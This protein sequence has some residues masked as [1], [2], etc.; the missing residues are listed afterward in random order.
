MI[1][2]TNMIHNERNIFHTVTMVVLAILFAGLLCMPAVT[3]DQVKQNT[4]Q[5]VNTTPHIEL[6]SVSQ[7]LTPNPDQKAKLS[8]IQQLVQYKANKTPAQGKISD[9][10][11]YLI[12][13]N[14]PELGN[15]RDEKKKT[16]HDYFHAFLY[17]AEAKNKFGQNNSG[18]AS[19]ELAHVV[20]QVKPSTSIQEISP[21]L[22]NITSYYSG[23]T[24]LTAWVDL[25][26]LPSLASDK[27]VMSIDFFQYHTDSSYPVFNQNTSPYDIPAKTTDTQVVVETTPVP[28]PAVTTS[29]ATPISPITSCLALLISLIFLRFN[30]RS[31]ENE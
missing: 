10:L 29:V 25:N 31:G 6:I 16:W 1:G 8:A 26:S 23:D 4:S 19:G 13:P 27:N 3:A 12:D 18:N 21:Y 14:Y 9:D 17:S 11:L 15:T 28:S 24:L 2:D 22:T 7:T 30:A 5:I 20:I